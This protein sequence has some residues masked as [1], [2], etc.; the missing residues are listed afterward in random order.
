[1]QTMRTL[2]VAAALGALLVM[3][4]VAADAPSARALPP[5][6]AEKLPRWRGFNLLEKRGL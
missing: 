6:S 2:S 3:P 4:S 1:M 5:A